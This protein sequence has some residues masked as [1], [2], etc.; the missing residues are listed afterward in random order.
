MTANTTS[1]MASVATNSAVFRCTTTCSQTSVQSAAEERQYMATVVGFRHGMVENP[2]G[3]IYAQLPGFPLAA[4]GLRLAEELGRLLAAAPVSAVFASPLERAVQTAGA[5]A[6]PHG[7]E[8]VPD[9]R[10]I[11]WSF[12]QRW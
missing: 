3:V 11:E 6:G 12:W 10:L 9:R 4:D 7:L 5:L 1:A 8:V 2:R